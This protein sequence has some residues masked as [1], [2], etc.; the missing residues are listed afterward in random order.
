M[1]DVGIAK[2]LAAWCVLILGSG[3]QG[4]IGFGLGMVGAPLLMLIDPAM[5]PGPLLADS[6]LLTLLMAR[7]ERDGIKFS[8]LKWALTGRFIGVLLAMFAL[9]LLPRERTSLAVGCAVLLA[10]ALASSGL[11]LRL[12]PGS[13]VAAG[14]LSGLTGTISSIGGPPMALIYQ[15]AEGSHLRGSLSAYFVV[16]A[17]M[18]LAALGV[19]GRFGWSELSLAVVLAPGVLLGF[20]ASAGAA[21]RVDGRHLRTIVLVVSAAAALTVILRQLLGF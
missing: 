2:T 5:V 4:T 21:R 10:V 19:V 14:T 13:L 3:L 8:E 20:L 17:A 15:H 9:V 7:R 11:R 18:S 16:G 6:L 12:A 1:F